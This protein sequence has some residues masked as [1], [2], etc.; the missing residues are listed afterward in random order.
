M[1]SNISI[2][3][4]TAESLKGT[5]QETRNEPASHST[6]E[7]SLKKQNIL[8]SWGTNSFETY[9]AHSIMKDKRLSFFQKILLTTNGTVTDLLILYTKEPIHANK[10]RQ[11]FQLSADSD[12]FLGPPGM[13]LLKRSVLLR[14]PSRQYMYANSIFVF[15]R[16]SRSIQYK[17]LETEQPIGLL[18]KEEKLETYR[19]ILG[20]TVAPSESVS[21]HFGE[22]S[23]SL[24]VSRTYLIYHQQCILG[25]ITE[26][27]PLA[28]F[29]EG[30]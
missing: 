23:Q 12:A 24:I 15:E 19:E 18:W 13:P 8:Q 30:L 25:I 11:E 27:F 4:D 10:L 22:S 16:F 21:R 20:Y 17:L 26:H 7:L 2:A 5:V 28:Y 6:Q 14:S 29:K 3:H 1:Q 9:S